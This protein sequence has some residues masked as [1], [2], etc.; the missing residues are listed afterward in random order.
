MHIDVSRDADPRAAWLGRVNHDLCKRLLWPA[1]DRRALGGPVRPGELIAQL[2]DDEGKPATALAC[3]RLLRAEAPPLP[4]ALDGFERA[5]ADAERAAAA[6]D[7][8]GVLAL[9]AA[10]DLLAR[11]VKEATAAR[12]F[13]D[14]A[15]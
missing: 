4:E 6:D 3:W 11:K 10:F 12:V 15:P 2:T 14:P 13:E 5:V 9:E 8:S 7:L 1:R